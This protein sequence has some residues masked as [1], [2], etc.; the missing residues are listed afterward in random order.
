M[1]VS[2]DAFT[3][4]SKLEILHILHALMRK[5][6][7]ITVNVDSGAFFL[8][9]LLGIDEQSNRLYFERGRAAAGIPNIRTDRKISYRTKLEQVEIRFSSHGL[10]TTTYGGNEAYEIPLP[11]E[12]QRIQ[13]RESYRVHTPL[14]KALKCR[15]TLAASPKADTVELNIINISCGG[16]AIQ[17]PPEQFK[18]QIGDRYDCVLLLPD[19]PGLRVTVTVCDTNEARLLN[20]KK[21]QHTGCAFVSPPES[22]LA[23]IQRYI[24]VLERQQRTQHAMHG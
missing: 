15:L 11:E 20:G 16:I 18:P 5:A 1:A 10:H 4:G 3:I 12:L 21:S 22:T 8:T 13:R 24:M 14:I 7:L 19:T 17:C 23:T 9:S 2:H 6:A